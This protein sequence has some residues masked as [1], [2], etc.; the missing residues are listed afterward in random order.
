[1]A[2]LALRSVRKPA[3]RVHWVGFILL[4]A[5]FY[6]IFLLALAPASTFGWVIEKVTGQSV[7]LDQAKGSLW[8]GQADSIQLDVAPGRPLRLNH[9]SWRVLL[10]SL[11]RGE[12]ATRLELQDG[13]TTG[14]A[15]AA[16]QLN[17][18]W[19]LKQVDLTAP[20][21]TLQPLLATLD[22]IQP[23]GAVHAL[24]DDFTLGRSAYAGE[25]IIEWRN[26]STKLSPI[27]PIGEY[28]AKLSGTPAA[29]EYV[30]STVDGPLRIEGKGAWS[31]QAGTSFSG[32]ARAEPPRQAELADLLKLMGKDLG[33]G[34]RSLKF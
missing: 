3:D 19:R 30:L 10:F 7:V 34:V 11:L 27:V 4:G 16:W 9:L 28:R 20:A 1:M 25:A 15:T 26:A 12:L 2:T 21:A 8:R 33:G 31:T 6:A 23:G 17:G 18:A 24:S 29:V 14:H 32:A 22:F 5:A 13:A